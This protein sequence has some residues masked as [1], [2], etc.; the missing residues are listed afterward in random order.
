MPFNIWQNNLEDF[1]DLEKIWLKQQQD[2]DANLYS[3]HLVVYKSHLLNYEYKVKQIIADTNKSNKEKKELRELCKQTFTNLYRQVETVPLLS[4]LTSFEY[5]LTQLIDE[6][7]YGLYEAYINSDYEY[8]QSAHLQINTKQ[9]EPEY[10]Q[11][12]KITKYTNIPIRAGDT[13]RLDRPILDVFENNAWIESED[14]SRNNQTYHYT[15]G[16]VK[17]N[18]SIPY[19]LTYTAS[20]SPAIKLMIRDIYPKGKAINIFEAS[21]APDS[22]KQTIQKIVDISQS[23]YSEIQLSIESK[24]PLNTKSLDKFKITFAPFFTPEID[25]YKIDNL[26][27]QL[28]SI[29]YL[30]SHRIQILNSTK[31]LDTYIFTSL[32]P[33]WKQTN[34]TPIK[35]G[36]IA[37]I[38]YTPIPILIVLVSFFTL[39][40]IFTSISTLLKVQPYQNGKKIHTAVYDTVMQLDTFA[41]KSTNYIKKV[42]LSLFRLY[43]S[44][45]LLGLFLF[46]PLMFLFAFGLI[47]Y[48]ESV[49]C[50]FLILWAIV[51][52]LFGLSSHMSYKVAFICLAITMA[53]TVIGLPI[54]ANNFA[55]V[56]YVFFIVGSISIETSKNFSIRGIPF[57]KKFN[58]YLR[59]KYTARETIQIGV[60]LIVCS[61]TLVLLFYSFATAH[62]FI[63]H[64]SLN[65]VIIKIEP[66]LVYP[67]TKVIIY[68]RG[69]GWKEKKGYRLMNN[70]GE[71][72]TDLWTDSKI[73]FTVPL[74]WSPSELNFW[75]EKPIEWAGRAETARSENGDIRLLQRTNQWNSDDDEYFKQ[76]KYLEKETLRLNGYE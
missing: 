34:N 43:S 29:K 47:G 3:L 72:Q 18:K 45:I 76:L 54:I 6:K 42:N 14:I 23:K 1:S 11:K 10:I 13:L 31:A 69:F 62:Q 52:K 53:S 44:L 71:V 46:I 2:V 60:G 40:F 38:S 4:A 16:P 65:P 12:S 64:S 19:L 9:F 32:G 70:L 73:I 50:M 35:N 20:N 48:K 22:Q 57:L 67:S 26:P 37:E 66:R 51:V 58:H 55:I 61:F 68:G 56:A 25:I 27:H 17:I 41:I 63:I 36:Y 39:A 21:F 49:I 24:K 75:I 8:L 59:R 30:D 33:L 5:P 28:S 7:E 15:I 74:H